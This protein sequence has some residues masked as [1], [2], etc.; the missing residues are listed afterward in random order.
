MKYILFLNSPTSGGKG[1]M[2]LPSFVNMSVVSN[3]WVRSWPKFN[4]LMSF[5]TIKTVQYSFLYDSTKTACLGTIW[6]F[7]Y[8]L[9]KFSANKIAISMEGTNRSLSFFAWR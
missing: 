1:L 2:K 9:K 8:D 3:Q 6:F 5:F 7:S 4:P